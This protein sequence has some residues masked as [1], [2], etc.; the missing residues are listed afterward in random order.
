VT[1]FQVPIELGS[2]VDPDVRLVAVAITGSDSEVEVKDK[3][4]KPSCKWENDTK[5][6]MRERWIKA[7]AVFVRRT[8]V[9]RS[10]N[11]TF[12]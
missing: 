7:W 4:F 2:L 10:K 11:V 6:G 1:N 5:K 8:V 3:F 9:K 12:M